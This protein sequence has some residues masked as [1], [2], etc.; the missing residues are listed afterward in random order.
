MLVYRVAKPFPD[1]E[2][3]TIP[4]GPYTRGFES[5]EMEELSDRINE[6]HS[7][8]PAS[9]WHPSPWRDIGLD[10]QVDEYCGFVSLDQL[11]DW[12][13]GWFVELH[14]HGFLGYV[15]DVPAH[16]VRYGRFQVVA[17]L[18]QSWLVETFPL[19]GGPN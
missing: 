19:C 2:E 6:A 10:I 12:F 3:T 7:Y 4:H 9:D 15:Y 13:K 14:R 5:E 1:D 8:G 11:A 17:P 16:L 18:K